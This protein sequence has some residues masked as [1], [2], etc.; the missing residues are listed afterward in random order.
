MVENNQL[1]TWLI[2]LALVF[3]VS[4]PIIIPYTGIGLSSFVYILVIIYAMFIGRIALNT[5][6]FYSFV[7]LYVLLITLFSVNGILISPVFNLFLWSLFLL[8]VVALKDKFE[9]LI[10][11]KIFV[12]ISFFVVIYYLI[13]GDYQ[14]SRLT[15]SE[16]FNPTWLAYQLVILIFATLSLKSI[17][18]YYRFIALLTFVIAL[19]LTQGKTAFL[20]LVLSFLIVFF[21]RSRHKLVLILLWATLLSVLYFLLQ[22]NI[23][24]SKYFKFYGNL[25]SGDLDIALSGRWGLWRESLFSYFKD[26]PLIPLGINSTMEA[27]KIDN[28]AHNVFLTL[29]YELG[30]LFTILYL[31]VFLYWVRYSYLKYKS[32]VPST[33]L[34]FLLISGI[35]NDVFYYKYFWL[36]LVVAYLI[37]GSMRSE[38]S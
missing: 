35:G 30:I 32:V 1:L 29:T 38:K 8:S 33:S 26:Y 15:P 25:F 24:E 7:L 23:T 6:N 16:E 27:L 36:G 13:F 14:S 28:G 18:L 3:N 9:P 12:F 4:D 19:I 34:L 21:I 20:G 37:S 17:G 2:S 10:V 22:E 11:L 31:F 5:I